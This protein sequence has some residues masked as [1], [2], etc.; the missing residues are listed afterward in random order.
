MFRHWQELS[1]GDTWWV[2][3]GGRPGHVQ[4]IQRI[5]AVR[6][7]G[8]PAWL[9]SSQVREFCALGVALCAECAHYWR[10]G[11]TRHQQLQKGARNETTHATVDP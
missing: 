6:G 9:V 8:P 10:Q 4:L 3:A 7:K 5:R 2:E 11:Q 1:N